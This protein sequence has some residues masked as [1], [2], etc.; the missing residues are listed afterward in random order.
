MEDSDTALAAVR[1]EAAALHQVLVA[2]FKNQGLA[3]EFDR[4]AGTNLAGPGSAI[5][6]SVDMASGRNNTDLQRFLRLAQNVV[7]DRMKDATL[8]APQLQ[9]PPKVNA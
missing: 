6:Q 7:R 8:K 9:V 2:A 5:E 4:L 3:A 1:A